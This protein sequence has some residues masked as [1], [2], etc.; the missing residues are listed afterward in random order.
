[1][2]FLGDDGLLHHQLQQLQLLRPHS[3]PFTVALVLLKCL[4]VT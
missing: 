2:V 3:L 4:Q 1:M